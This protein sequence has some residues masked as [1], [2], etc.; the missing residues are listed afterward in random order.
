MQ[1]GRLT[2]EE[3]AELELVTRGSWQSRVHYQT[4]GCEDRE[5]RME[6]HEMLGLRETV[7]QWNRR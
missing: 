5:L 4:V 7:A 3:S 2:Q 6:L 1:A